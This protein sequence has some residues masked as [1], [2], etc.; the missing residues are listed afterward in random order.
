MKATIRQ[1]FE[2]AP[3]QVFFINGVQALSNCAFIAIQPRTSGLGKCAA[4]GDSTWNASNLAGDIHMC[5]TRQLDIT[6]SD[7]KA[8]KPTAESGVA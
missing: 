2:R 1:I 4:C 7:Y 5:V 3:G 6:F 8:V